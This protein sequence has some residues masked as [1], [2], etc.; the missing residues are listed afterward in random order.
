M[1]TCHHPHNQSKKN[2]CQL[3]LLPSPL[4]NSSIERLRL[5]E[6]VRDQ[7]HIF[8][9]N[10]IMVRLRQVVKAKFVLTPVFQFHYGAIKTQD[11]YKL[12]RFKRLFQFHYGAIKTPLHQG[13][14]A[15]NLVSIPIWCD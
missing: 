5:D 7:A 11:W 3:F 2:I 15:T 4:F 14:H 8:G 13:A 6:A 1:E 12:N 10:S 9:F